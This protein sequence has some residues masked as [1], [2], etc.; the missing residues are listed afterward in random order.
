MGT[1]SCARYD[2]EIGTNINSNDLE[3]G[4]VQDLIMR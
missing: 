2:Y 1:W 4:V 3:H